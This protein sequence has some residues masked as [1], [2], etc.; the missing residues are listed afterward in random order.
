MRR[1]LLRKIVLMLGI[2][3]CI[4]ATWPARYWIEYMRSPE[5]QEKHPDVHLSQATLGDID[6]T[7]AA[8]LLVLGGLRG[9]AAN[10]LWVRAEDLQRQH[11]WAELAV[12]VDRIIKLQPH[13][14]AVW[15]FQSW[16]LAYNVSSEWDQV[17][18]KYYWIREGIRFA[19]RGTEVNKHEET[20][21]WWTGWCYFHKI[22]KADEARLL[23]EIFRKDT[24][25]ELD[26][27]G[28]QHPPFNPKQ[29]DNFEAAEEW[30]EKAVAKVDELNRPPRQ[31]AEVAFRSYPGHARIQ[32]AAAAEQD[33]QFGDEAARK[34]QAALDRWLEFG[35]R[36]YSVQDGRLFVR[37]DYRPEVFGAFNRARVGHTLAR[38][39]LLSVK[40][41]EAFKP[42][43]REK[44]AQQFKEAIR[45]M[46]DAISMTRPGVLRELKD[47]AADAFAAVQQQASV[48]TSLDPQLLATPGPEGDS[49]RRRFQSFFDVFHEYYKFVDEE[50]YWSDR[51]GGL[52]N[53]NYW[54]KRC[55]VEMEPDTLKAREY[56]YIAQRAF[57]RGDLFE[58]KDA[59]E[60][61]FQLWAQV[62]GRDIVFALDD[63]T[64]EETRD[65]IVGR[66][67]Y[68]RLLKQLDEPA[69]PATHPI[70]APFY[71][72]VDQ[73]VP[74]PQYEE[75]MR[76][77]G[78]LE[79]NPNMSPEE[80]EQIRA[81]MEELLR[82]GE[83]LKQRRKERS[84]R[85]LQ[86]AAQGEKLIEME[87]PPEDDAAGSNSASPEREHQPGQ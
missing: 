31:M 81:R 28:R 4:L 6:P 67:G 29:L 87:I 52:V 51:Y 19:R 32:H 5:Y 53:Y 43:N 82:E 3:A 22:G 66:L 58:A 7:N 63:Q 1:S 69:D 61:A 71:Y 33:G 2:L 48:L 65:Y 78:R 73:F 24:E 40:N 55:V 54:K 26:P 35:R 8:L 59:F 80:Q 44:L 75:A 77:Y 70:M 85:L 86:R 72:M 45:Y 16:N 60:Q 27:R 13:F 46:S 11:R 47:G 18:D 56:F 20:L 41:P 34:W 76:L 38:G 10:Y 21:S 79:R 68:Q 37:L 14:V 25:P 9:V 39:A 36:D 50:L 12:E 17:D 30:F 74:P 42:G 64:A 23:R 84:I 62:L 49:E 57:E 83:L 15:R